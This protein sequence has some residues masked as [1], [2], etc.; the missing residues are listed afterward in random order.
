LQAKDDGITGFSLQR[1]IEIKQ[2]CL[3]FY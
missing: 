2:I 3:V 1:T